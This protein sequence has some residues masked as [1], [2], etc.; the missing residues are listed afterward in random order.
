MKQNANIN[1]TK[2]KNLKLQKLKSSKVEKLQKLKIYSRFL[3]SNIN[4]YRLTG[5]KF[6]IILRSCFYN[7]GD[8]HTTV[9]PSTSNSNPKWVRNKEEE[10]EEEEGEE[11]SRRIAGQVSLCWSTSRNTIAKSHDSTA[12]FTGHGL[13]EY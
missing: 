8:F 5:E 6:R 9:L 13:I 3:R 2:I 12:L 1:L 10:E 7:P 4:H 11:K